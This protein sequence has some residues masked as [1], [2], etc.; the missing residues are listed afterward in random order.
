MANQIKRTMKELSI[1]EK[2]ARYDEAIENERIRKEILEYFQQ[3]ENEE[4]RGVNI[5]DWIA[6]LEN[7]KT[8]FINNTDNSFICDIKN[9]IDEAPGVL[10]A[11]K[12]RLIAW[13]E[14]QG[15]H[16]ENYDE[17]EKEKYDFVSGQYIQCR[18]SFNEFKE[19]DS[20]WLEYI[21]NDT[22]IGRS[23]NI[24]NQKFH[25]TPRQLYRLF[26]QQHFS[27]E[28]NTND[29]TN[30]P[31]EYGKYVDECLNEASKH[32]FSEGEDKYSVA[33]L[34]YAGVRC[35]KSWLEKQGEKST[36]KIEPK[37]KI[38]K[39][40]WYV[41]IKD[42]LDNYANKAF[43]KGDTYLS[44]QDGSLMPSN[45]NV[46][47]EVACPDTYFRDWTIQDAKDGDVVVD[48]SFGNIGIF[49][50]IGNHPDG[51][52][53]NDTSYC[54]LH[55]RYDDGF[56]YAD[57][58]D[59]N[60]IDSDDLI[61]ATKEQR[62]LLFQKIKEAGYEWDAEKKELKKISQEYPLTTDECI[63]PAWSEE[64]NGHVLIISDIIEDKKK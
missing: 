52:S 5:S 19:Y 58:E 6:W 11:D 9:I 37:F 63:K 44:T 34:F 33:D 2:A 54:Y 49:E 39:D 1:E 35:G 31:T 29:E 16:L 10:Q 64:D 7:V 30:A 45:S 42:L 40:K 56:F 18:A 3:F 24:L 27:K 8:P 36:D 4:L 43:Y 51:G 41:C 47:F 20:Y 15:G 17:A 14:K 53:C 46:P 28:D 50:S 12:N 60:T 38:E 62:D 57:F 59:G 21:G 26:S 13:L 23:D 48:K 32:F 55:C 22:Y 25:I 61:P